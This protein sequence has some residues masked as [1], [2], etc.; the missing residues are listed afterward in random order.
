M[1]EGEVDAYL[2]THLDG[3]LGEDRK[4]GEDEGRREGRGLPRGE[5]TSS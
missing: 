3:F 1:S 5:G 2:K 4:E